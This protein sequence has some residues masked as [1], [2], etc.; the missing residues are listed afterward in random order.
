MLSGILNAGCDTLKVVV[1]LVVEGAVVV[2]MTLAVEDDSVDD[3]GTTACVDVVIGSAVV[4]EVASGVEVLVCGWGM[5]VVAM[6]VGVTGV[7]IG[8]AVV[9]EVASGVEVLVSGEVAL[10]ESSGVVVS[11]KFAP[12]VAGQ[13]TKP[14]SSQPR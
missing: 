13:N 5:C 1:V 12:H 14:P 11:Q 3:E 9:E 10:V 2:D 7:V 8:S 4:E 6:V